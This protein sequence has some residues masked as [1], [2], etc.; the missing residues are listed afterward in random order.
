MNDTRPEDL[1]SMGENFFNTLCK[2]VGFVANSSKSDDKGG[3]DFEVEHRRTT[4]INYSS[5]SYPVY[6]V[7][8]KSTTGKN[9]TKLTFGNLLKLI[10]YNGASF[11]VLIKY[12]KSIT[13]DKAYIFHINK[14]FSKSILEE[15][16]NKQ[17]KSNNFALNRNE[18]I[19]KFSSENEIDPLDGVG[20]KKSF[21]KHIGPDYLKYVENKLKYLS[22]FEKEGKIRQFSWTFKNEQD[23]KSMANCFLGYEEKFK[24]DIKE[25]S[26]PFGIKDK[27]P[28][29]TFEDY[30]TT[31]SPHH[32]KLP[33]TTIYFKTSKFGKQYEFTGTSYIAPE[34]LRAFS[35]RARTKCKLFDF[36]FDYKA[37]S[38]SIETKDVF[39]ENIEVEFKEL[40]NFICF[41]N[42]SINSK[43]TFIKL[44]D[45]ESKKTAE[46][47]IGTPG[48]DLP[49]NFEIIFSAMR[50]TYKKLCEFNIE[51]SV[52][53]TRYLWDNIGRFNLFSIIGEKYD[54]DY[55]LEF[56]SRGNHKPEVDVVI[57]NSTIEFKDANLLTFVAFYGSVER[58]R[59]NILLGRFNKSELL[60]DFL[61]NDEDDCKEL[62]KTKSEYFTNS[63]VTK[64]F[65][66]LD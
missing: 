47:C 25:Y 5:Q 33:Q 40:Y 17:L 50:S 32:D 56:E 2:S 64:G 19:I 58:V 61:F 39:A 42:D 37:R 51:N 29:S 43:E 46:V 59:D 36:I 38:V 28:I 13:P 23:I 6:R 22:N 52:I 4:E 49:N 63:L 35:Q 7:Q 15:I 18:K 21:D 57:F 65:K 26:A 62:I 14:D 53:S 44:V 31:I 48:F 45:C 54:P 30:N 8:V 41:I 12:S 3:W 55:V 1:G 27:I 10:Q 20:L 24:I 60:G 11:I 16:R 34:Q 9:Q 66:V